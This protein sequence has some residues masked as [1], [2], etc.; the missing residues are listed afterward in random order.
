[1][2][3]RLQDPDREPDKEPD[4]EEPGKERYGE[5]QRICTGAV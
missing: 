2:Q 3:E 4:E 1:V 5:P